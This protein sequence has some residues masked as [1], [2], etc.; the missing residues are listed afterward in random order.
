MNLLAPTD[1]C[2]VIGNPIDHSLSPILHNAGYEAL[3]I[4]SQYI[5]IK[6]NISI[7][8]SEDVLKAVKILQIKG[9]S[10]TAPLKQ[11]VMQFLDDI[12][13]AATEIGA[14]NTIV[15]LN[16][17]LK[18]YNTDWFGIEQPLLQIP[19]LSQKKIA[20]IGAGG[21]ARAAVYALRNTS[22][23][24]TIFNRTLDHALELADD[25]KVHAEP[26]S[27]MKE[28]D[29]FDIILLA[30]PTGNDQTVKRQLMNYLHKNQILFN[31]AYGPKEEKFMSDVTNAGLKTI[32]GYE[33][34]FYQA[35]KQF[36]LFTGRDAPAQ[37]MRH[38]LKSYTGK[39]NDD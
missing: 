33:M 39:E 31:L 18:G 23:Q 3:G 11:S 20:V 24:L 1:V 34:L 15:N 10:V 19:A 28:I 37:E 9:I 29:K 5:Y 27:N 30:L 21:A 36:Q 13:I 7:E 6:R 16:G 8:Q 12:D 25:F 22:Q 14:V 2:L 17:T 26:I 32:D 4:E 35:L 38:A